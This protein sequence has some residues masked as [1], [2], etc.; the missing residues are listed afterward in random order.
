M[1]GV[2]LTNKEFG[3]RRVV[4][5]WVAGRLRIGG[6]TFPDLINLLVDTGAD[7]TT[8][9]GSSHPEIEHAARTGKKAAVNGVGG[10]WPARL[11]QHDIAL[12][13][14]VVNLETNE[15]LQAEL[16]LPGMHVMAR[17]AERVGQGKLR[18][19]GAIPP[20]DRR[21]K[22]G[23]I[24]TVSPVPNLLGR[25]LFPKNSLELR[26]KPNG[27]SWLILLDATLDEPLPA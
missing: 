5:P 21:L 25:D 3:N 6:Q 19:V 8:I 18:E 26:W 24:Q 1:Y 10:H 14:Q 27:D 4:A 17:H 12:T 2:P 20:D 16:A 23:K 22:A 15:Q 7:I 13:V 11:L 9:N